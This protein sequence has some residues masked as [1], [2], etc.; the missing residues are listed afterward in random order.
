MLERRWLTSD[1]E[2]SVL[3]LGTV[4]LGHNTGVKYPTVFDLPSDAEAANL[5]AVAR[6][7]GINL[8][9]TAPAYGLAE[10]RLGQLIKGQ[11][12]HWILGSKVGE[13]YDGDSHFDFTRSGAERSLARSL[14]RLGT[15]HLDYCLLHSD[16]NDHD[17]LNSGA[18]DALARARDNGDVR[19]IGVSS[20]TLAG[21]MRAIE[22]GLDIV[23]LT[24]NPE[25]RDEIPAAQQALDANTGVLV[26]KAMGSGHLSA[27][28]SLSMVSQV[29]GVSAIITGTLNPAH[30]RA[31]VQALI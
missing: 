10:M 22:L 2:V 13:D 9:D 11:R 6:E 26:K 8:L 15:D 20:K 30:L 17:V 19:A 24:I 3:G 28:E 16:G 25:H 4:K 18:M 14:T 1:L 29:P 27:S 23:M 21:A 31:N 7:L 5:L 12:D